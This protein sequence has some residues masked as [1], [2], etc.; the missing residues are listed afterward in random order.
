ML[1]FLKTKGWQKV[2]TDERFQ[3]FAPPKEEKLEDPN[4]LYRIPLHEQGVD[5][6]AFTYR[7]LISFSQFYDIDLQF[8][9]DL[10]SKDLAQIAQEKEIQERILALAS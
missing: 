10:L 3:Y 9:F 8:L 1:L 5:Y 2:K 7:L 4:F 6:E